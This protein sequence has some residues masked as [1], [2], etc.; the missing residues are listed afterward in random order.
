MT[1]EIKISGS[2]PALE[3]ACVPLAT[4]AVSEDSIEK[5]GMDTVKRTIK[6]NLQSKTGEWD[7]FVTA[8]RE[9]NSQTHPDKDFITVRNLQ[10]DFDHYTVPAGISVKGGEI[11]VELIETY[12]GSDEDYYIELG[13]RNEGQQESSFE[14]DAGSATINSL[15]AYNGRPPL[16]RDH[17]NAPLSEE[18]AKELSAALQKL[19]KGLKPNIIT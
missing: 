10:V 15:R 8:W 17:A 2:K 1:T 6:G 13:R 18:K 14:G 3:S 11:T 9:F 19:G 7:E 12:E 5:H 16:D 4:I